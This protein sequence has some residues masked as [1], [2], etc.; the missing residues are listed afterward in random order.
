MR[1]RGL[2]A[3]VKKNR[4]PGRKYFFTFFIYIRAGDSN[5]FNKQAGN[6]ERNRNRKPK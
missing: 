2:A 6:R 1:F 3:G 4:L 5:F